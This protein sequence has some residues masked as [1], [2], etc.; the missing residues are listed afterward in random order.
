MST[1]KVV[2]NKRSA[3]PDGSTSKR[4][5]LSPWPPLT[6]TIK[7]HAAKDLCCRP[8]L[9]K[10]D[11]FRN[12][13]RSLVARHE[14]R[15]GGDI[16]EYSVEYEYGRSG[17]G[18][19]YAKTPSLQ[20]MCKRVRRWLTDGIHS[21]LDIKNCE[22]SF[23]VA[24]GPELTPVLKEY[25]DN[26]DDTLKFLNEGIE[27]Y[28]KEDEDC[29]DAKDGELC[30]AEDA[31]HLILIVM[32][33]AAKWRDWVR[34]ADGDAAGFIDRLHKEATSYWKI[35]PQ[36]DYPGLFEKYQPDKKIGNRSK[37]F[38]AV[39]FTIEAAAL[40]I[41]EAVAAAQGVAVRVRCFDGLMVDYREDYP[42][43]MRAMEAGVKR[44]LGVEIT[45][46]NKTD[47]LKMTKEDRKLLKT[48][49]KT[50]CKGDFADLKKQK[51]HEHKLWSARGA[52]IPL[53]ETCLRHL[54]ETKVTELLRLI[55]AS[56]SDEGLIAVV[57]A[58]FGDRFKF[59]EGTECWYYTN[60]HN[61]WNQGKRMGYRLLSAIQADLKVAIQALWQKG[62]DKFDGKMS[63]LV[64][65]ATLARKQKE[66]EDQARSHEAFLECDFA[67]KLDRPEVVR[68]IFPFQD[69]YVELSGGALKLYTPDMGVSL[70]TGYP[71]PTSVDEGCLQKIRSF[72]KQVLPHARVRSFFIDE[73]ARCLQPGNQ[74]HDILCAIGHTRNGKGTALR[75]VE[76]AFGDLAGE[77][78]FENLAP[79]GG[80]EKPRSSITTIKNKRIVFVNEASN[81]DVKL[82]EQLLN[83]LS[84]G[85]AF[86]MRALHENMGRIQPQFTMVF[87]MNDPMKVSG[88]RAT[89]ALQERLKAVEFPVTFYDETDPR[90]D[91]N[92]AL[93]GIKNPNLDTEFSKP[94]MRNAMIV[95][96]LN[97][98][99]GLPTPR[100]VPD[101]VRT[102]TA[103]TRAAGDMVASAMND[104]VY[105]TDKKF[106]IKAGKLICIGDGAVPV[107]PADEIA[108]ALTE[109]LQNEHNHK[110]SMA[111]ARRAVERTTGRAYHKNYALLDGRAARVAG[112]TFN[113][114]VGYLWKDGRE[115]V[116]F[117]Y[118][119][120]A[121]HDKAVKL[122]RVD[123]WMRDIYKVV[124]EASEGS[125]SGTRIA[126]PE[127]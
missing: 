1:P 45:V 4:P 124:E 106:V 108:K 2:M 33:G 61:V 115:K 116:A 37:Y 65:K 5:K 25:C 82:D 39:H 14:A 125:F 104:L 16:L 117:G 127:I 57:A 126:D 113:G 19:G 122:R 71:Y 89:D 43:L 15:G 7:Y 123:I 96:L 56:E 50:P 59:N 58:A 99:P 20:M 41:C 6:E 90:Y 79:A 92:D 49:P 46:V 76:R 84:G 54:T 10:N 44:E 9:V 85:D 23:T 3:S 63:L 103:E 17:S 77:L 74:H 42:D 34:S 55:E 81:D 64:T 80:P 93:I 28:S 88:S 48:R 97:R 78:Q 8:D 91:A 67:S 75:L 100:V 119:G 36:A 120:T 68:D 47:A 21:D 94:E 121:M 72:L 30:H 107:I 109:H 118:T 24:A 111:D 105:R 27:F 32:N 12:H 18:R 95:L 52:D 69:G 35:Y 112:G 51:A 60:E 73:L 110:M 87:S 29:P 83:Q 11:A 102:K 98:F 62:G 53:G 101:E 22:P 13:L 26:R 38:C 66:L 31:K 114:V 40:R 86:S 70:T